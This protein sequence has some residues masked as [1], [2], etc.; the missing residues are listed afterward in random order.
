MKELKF[1]IFSKKKVTGPFSSRV[2]SQSPPLF[3]Y[4]LPKKVVKMLTNQEGAR[5]T[6][7]CWSK[8]T[9]LSPFSCLMTSFTFNKPG[10]GGGGEYLRQKLFFSQ[11]ENFARN[12]QVSKSFELSSNPLTH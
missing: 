11:L 8:Y 12:T 10:G 4:F 3:S 6:P 7:V 2:A 5:E 9:T 1:A